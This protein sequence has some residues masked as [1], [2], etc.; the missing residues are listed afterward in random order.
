MS[1]TKRQSPPCIWKN[2]DHCLQLSLLTKFHI[3]GNFVCPVIYGGTWKFCG[4]GGEEKELQQ[5]QA[6]SLKSCQLT[7]PM[8]FGC[9]IW[10]SL[11][12][13]FSYDCDTL[14]LE[15]SDKPLSSSLLAEFS[16]AVGQ[17]LTDLL[18]H[19]RHLWQ[20]PG[21]T[22]LV[23]KYTL[24]TWNVPQNM[25]CWIRLNPCHWEASRYENR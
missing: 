9:V 23:I 8:E 10:R 22:V 7:D 13:N 2:R 12:P 4:E 17:I 21:V 25:W 24:I 1:R 11:T 19:A 6:M 15:T 14:I 20:L 5:W 3:T 18:L 16:A